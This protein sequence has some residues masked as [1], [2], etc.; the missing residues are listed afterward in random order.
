MKILQVITKSSLGGAQSVVVNL[1]NALCRMGHEVGVVAGEGDG[2]LWS[3]LDKDVKQYPCPYLQRSVSLKNDVLAVWFMHRLNRELRPDVVHLHSSK[4][5]M[6]GRVAF[7]GKKIIYTVHGFDSIRLAFRSFLPIERMMQYR[8]ASIIG[9][10]QHDVRTMKE[11]GIERRVDYVYNGISVLPKDGNLAWDVPDCY[12]KVVL[13]IARLS[14]PKKDDLFMEVARQLPDYAFVW[15]GN[16]KAVEQHPANV[17]FLGKIPNAGRYCAKADVLV[18]PSNYEGLPMVIL[19]AM[20]QGIPV[21][22]SNVGGVS[23]AV[24][25]GKTGFA[26]NNV[27]EDFVKAIREITEQPETQGRM[28]LC[29]K[30]TFEEKFTVDHMVDG[31]LRHYEKVVLH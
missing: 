26:V 31:Y 7:P 23:E 28:S 1:A 18:L 8:C 13:C 22:A 19:E 2:K 16:Q 17:F 29:A 20:A 6:L 3:L 15:I 10:S 12:R 11:E 25:H 24:V 14:P 27:P 21:V 4:A 30:H 5:G 9:V